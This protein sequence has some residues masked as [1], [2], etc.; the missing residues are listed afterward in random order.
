MEFY[1]INQY[2][3]YKVRNG[4]FERI[5][6]HYPHPKMGYRACLGLHRLGEKYGPKRLESACE[7]AL[8]AGAANYKS[9]KSILAHSLD[10][11][12]LATEPDAPRAA[13]SDN[14]RGAGYYQ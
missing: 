6:D 13:G 4:T 12:P 2:A 8:I 11:Q 7:R 1:P 5:L 10:S 14:I 3:G 9:V